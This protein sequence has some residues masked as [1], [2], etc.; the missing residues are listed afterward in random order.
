MFGISLGELV[1]I[2]IIAFLFLGPE[3]FPAIAKTVGKGIRDFKDASNQVKE[4]IV[5]ETKD[6]INIDVAKRVKDS[7]NEGKKSLDKEILKS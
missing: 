5:E 4:T 7:Y 1:I 6:V 3:K 2:A